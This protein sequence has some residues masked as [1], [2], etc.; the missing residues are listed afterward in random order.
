MYFD[1]FIIEKI[2]NPEK[3]KYQIKTT[4]E[5]FSGDFH[6]ILTDLGE[7]INKINEVATV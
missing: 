5:Y 6:N 2:E 7:I 4:G 3:Y 1:D